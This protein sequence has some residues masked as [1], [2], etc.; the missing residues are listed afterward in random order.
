ML[1]LIENNNILTSDELD[2]LN[3]EVVWLYYYVVKIVI[4]GA[5]PLFSFDVLSVF[6]CC[7]VQY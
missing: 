2:V 4:I 1:R 7:L 3:R 5:I 6:S